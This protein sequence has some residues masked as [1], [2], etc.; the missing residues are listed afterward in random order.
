MLLRSLSSLWTGW[1]NWMSQAHQDNKTMSVRGWRP[2][3][4][5]QDVWVFGFIGVY[6]INRMIKDASESSPLNQFAESVAE[7]IAES[8]KWVRACSQCQPCIQNSQG[9]LSFILDGWTLS[10]KVITISYGKF[11]P[12]VKRKMS[13]GKGHHH[14][15]SNTGKL[16][17]RNIN[18]R[19]NNIWTSVPWGKKGPNIVDHNLGDHFIIISKSNVIAKH[20]FDVNRSWRQDHFTQHDIASQNERV[21]R[22]SMTLQHF[23][24]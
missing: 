6:L 20:K 12:R 10:P 4:R 22:Y 13:K 1:V 17:E 7:S 15:I 9:V 24:W 11:L 23:G 21:K 19:A 14:I 8:A 5:R 2:V 3:W 18:E 16:F